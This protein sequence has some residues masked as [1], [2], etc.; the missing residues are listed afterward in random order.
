MKKRFQRG[1]VTTEMILML[2]VFMAVASIVTAAFKEGNF[3]ATVVSGPWRAIA[4]MAENGVWAAPASSLKQHP[5]VY[6]R[7]ASPQGGDP[8]Q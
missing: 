2:V 5:N 7:W 3:V 6:G 8:T 1:Q 4:G